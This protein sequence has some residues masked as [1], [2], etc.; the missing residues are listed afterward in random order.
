MYIAA[1]IGS[2]SAFVCS[3]IPLFGMPFTL[4]FAI[5]SIVFSILVLKKHDE[6][7]RKDA[8]IIALIIASISIVICITINI[9]STKF[10]IK[11]I[12]KIREL[13]DIDYTNYYNEKFNEYSLYDKE[14][15]NIYVGK[16]WLFK[17]NDI[18]KDGEYYYVNLN[19]EALN[20]NAYINIYDFG[21]FNFEK[22]E[23]SYPSYMADE[24]FISGFLEEGEQKNI[25][26][27]IP[28]SNE[29]NSQKYLVYI[30][31]ENGVK[32]RI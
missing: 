18:S 4:V 12:Q 15:E 2:I 14:N 21:I 8:S 1:L 7:E 16:D 23:F 28:C 30:D 19:I 25:T 20:S 27:K 6:K 26:L 11:T 9:F 3:C 5:T 13:D 31:N 22:N 24:N 10:I 17:I 32:I 29:E